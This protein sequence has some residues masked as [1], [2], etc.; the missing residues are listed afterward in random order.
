[1]LDENIQYNRQIVEMVSG[2]ECNKAIFES[3]HNLS[4]L[5]LSDQELSLLIPLYLSSP[6]NFLNKFL[7]LFY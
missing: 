1:M 4:V 3:N 7:F 6:S 5:N 2:S